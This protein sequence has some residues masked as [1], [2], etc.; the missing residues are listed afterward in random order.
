[1][2]VQPIGMVEVVEDEEEDHKILVALQGEQPLIDEKVEKVIRNFGE[3]Y[4]DHHPEKKLVTGRFL[5]RNEAVALV[6]KCSSN[7]KN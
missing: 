3:H 5:S 6:N 1:M 7:D 4:F 2:D